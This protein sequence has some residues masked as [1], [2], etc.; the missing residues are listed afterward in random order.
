MI[1]EMATY[2]PRP[3]RGGP[4]FKKIIEIDDQTRS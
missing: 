1:P 2:H 4:A 3:I